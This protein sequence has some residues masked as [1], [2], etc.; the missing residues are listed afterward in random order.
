MQY[1]NIILC[2]LAGPTRTQR[3]LADVGMLYKSENQLVVLLH[4]RIGTRASHNK[5]NGRAAHTKNAT[6]LVGRER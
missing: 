2:R 5:T 6:R 1:Y 3:L 4:E